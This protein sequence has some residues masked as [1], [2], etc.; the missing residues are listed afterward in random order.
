MY[1]YLYEYVF[2]Y[3]TVTQPASS[4]IILVNTTTM[5]YVT[6]T[7]N[8]FLSTF[9]SKSTFDILPTN[10]VTPNLSSLSAADRNNYES[11]LAGMFKESF[12]FAL[13]CYAFYRLYNYC[14]CVIIS[15]Y[16]NN[17]SICFYFYWI[18]LL[19]KKVRV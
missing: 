7:L 11:S 2:H 18:I 1:L 5:I 13:L 4:T 16:Y 19:Q 3:S 8:T 6:P 12:K 17:F 15:Y 9:T 10:Q 14:C